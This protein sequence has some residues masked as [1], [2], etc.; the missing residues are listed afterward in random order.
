[1]CFPKSSYFWDLLRLLFLPIAILVMVNLTAY[2]PFTRLAYA[3]VPLEAQSEN[4]EKSLR[5]SLPQEFPSDSKAP[6]ITKKTGPTGKVFAELVR[7]LH[8]NLKNI[9]G[10]Y[11]DI[12]VHDMGRMYEL[13]VQSLLNPKKEFKKFKKHL[14]NELIIREQKKSIAEEDENN[15]L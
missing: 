8:K 1:M 5:Q 11:E 4:I 7:G 12:N 9:Y 10:A 6:K 3:Q 15:E 13:F 2:V 14:S